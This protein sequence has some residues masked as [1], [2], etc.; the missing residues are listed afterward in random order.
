MK[1]NNETKIGIM[2]VIVVAL[3]VGLTIK[4]GNFNFSKEG[5]SLKVHFRNIDG[6]NENSPVMFNGFEVGI[7]KK[8]NILDD[9]S[10]IAMELELLIKKD[11]K[12]R[13]G[14]EARVKNLG[15]MGEKY[16]S[17][18]S[19]S[20]KGDYLV[21]GSVVEGKE[22]ADMGKIMED[23]EDIA[24]NLKEITANIDARLKANEA[25]I[26]Q[27]VANLDSTLEHAN[28]IAIN[29]DERLDKSKEKI[30]DAVSN[31]HAVSINLEEMSYDLKINPWK[32]LYREKGKKK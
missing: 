9:G 5:Y 24:K 18:S 27:I 16:I 23:G 11:A 4:T 8:V 1:I 13:Q 2:V 29:V 15:F 31:L 14:V 19:G 20:E 6:I 17:L 26:D 3:L 22:P 30:D 10:T 12:I 25:K 7:V 21:E 28:S 32:L